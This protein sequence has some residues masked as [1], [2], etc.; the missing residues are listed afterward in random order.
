MSLVEVKFKLF[1]RK[2]IIVSLG[3]AQVK[4][5]PAKRKL[6]QLSILS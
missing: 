5:G 4:A 1:N 3:L 2:I 6:S